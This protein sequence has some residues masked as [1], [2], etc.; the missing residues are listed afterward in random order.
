MKNHIGIAGQHNAGK[1]TVTQFLTAGLNEVC[2]PH[3]GPTTPYQHRH[4]AQPV[5]SALA[6]LTGRSLQ[7]LEEHKDDPHPPPGWNFTVREA[8]RRTGDFQPQI[9]PNALP[10]LALAE[11]ENHVFESLRRTNELRIFRER[12]YPT[13]LIWRP[14]HEDPTDTPTENELR[15]LIQEYTP[16]YTESPHPKPHL[17]YVNGDLVT[18]F[19][20]NYGT[21]EHLN[22]LVRTQLVD[23]L[24]DYFFARG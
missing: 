13:I 10:D 2:R 16:R 9:Y 8:M 23:E 1:T 6:V 21:R 19:L 4:L 18:Y 17:F 12:N 20:V 15:P 22:H 24:L 5:K 3:K 14:G 11:E 7:W